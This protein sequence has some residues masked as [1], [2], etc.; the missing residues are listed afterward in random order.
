MSKDYL[1]TH[2]APQRL[3]ENAKLL[4][5][6]MLTKNMERLAPSLHETDAQVEVILQFGIDQGIRFLTGTVVAQLT[7]Q[8]QRCME[9]FVHEINGEFAYG[10]VDSQ[11]RAKKLPQ[12]LDPIVVL[13]DN[14]NI[15]DMIEEELIINLPIVPMHCSEDCKVHLPLVVAT[16]PGA[17]EVKPN[18]F[19]VIESLKVKNKQE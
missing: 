16:Q 6:L 19:K 9:A 8:C 18:P 3:A 7:L 12:R 15:Q 10:I 14:L 2:V 1:P 5:G 13:E 4:R 17:E 11:E